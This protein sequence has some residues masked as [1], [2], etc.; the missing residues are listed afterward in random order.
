MRK[1]IATAAIVAGAYFGI[2]DASA[3]PEIITHATVIDSAGNIWRDVALLSE[4]PMIDE[5]PICELEDGSDAASLPCLWINQGNTYLT[6]EHYSYLVLD[7]TV[8]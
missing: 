6:F 2:A 1:S 7:D 8:K 3:C 5:F 4:L